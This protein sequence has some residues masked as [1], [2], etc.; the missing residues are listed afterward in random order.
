MTLEILNP[1][2]TS[3][4]SKGLV[5]YLFALKDSKKEDRPFPPEL[6]WGNGDHFQ[7]LIESVREQN[8]YLSFSINFTE[9][10]E[11]VGRET[12][13]QIAQIY[14]RHFAAGLAEN[15]VATICVLHDKDVNFHLHVGMYKRHLV[16]GG[17]FDPFFH[18]RD[19]EH[20]TLLTELCNL[21]YGLTSAREEKRHQ[22]LKIPDRLR[23]NPQKVRTY[24]Q[25]HLIGEQAFY[26]LNASDRDELIQRMIEL[27]TKFVKK[28]RDSITVL[29]PGG[30]PI[31]LR[32]FI[33]SE[34]FVSREAYFEN[35]T[36]LTAFL[37]QLRSERRRFERAL[38]KSY[39]VRAERNA[40]QSRSEHLACLTPKR[41]FLIPSLSK[42][43]HEKSLE[44]S[45]QRNRSPHIGET[46]MPY[47]IAR[48]VGELEKGNRI[49]TR[50]ERGSIGDTGIKSIGDGNAPDGLGKR[51]GVFS[52]R[53]VSSIE[54]S[55]LAASTALVGKLLEDVLR[56][57]IEILRMRAWRRHARNLGR[58]RKRQPD[59]R[60]TSSLRSL[61]LGHIVAD[62]LSRQAVKVA[63]SF[64]EFARQ[65]EQTIVPPRTKKKEPEMGM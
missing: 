57:P 1:K 47:P 19:R 3:K 51:D 37:T 39:R 61:G 10:L 45:A 16:T 38:W 9:K 50:P 14:C 65:P 43:H 52:K 46:R 18:R 2:V 24:Q 44:T 34:R 64:T 11:Q 36:K 29:T 56:I 23:G 5:E 15:D 21:A 53:D 4:R 54:R 35:K 12:A 8:A 32:G 26:S 25:E 6:I 22:K 58:G 7:R 13:V 40:R 17:R 30:E 42:R 55:T 27:G 62:V 48:S 63:E 41:R 49:E 28:N 20:F 59:E 33:Y 31:R 60:P